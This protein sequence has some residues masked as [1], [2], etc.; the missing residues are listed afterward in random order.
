MVLPLSL[1]RK[2]RWLS[3]I[4]FFFEFDKRD[5]I[6]VYLFQPAIVATGGWFDG[7]GYFF[8]TI[9]FGCAGFFQHSEGLCI[10]FFRHFLHS[11]F[12]RDLFPQWADTKNTR[13]T[14][15]FV[16]AAVNGVVIADEIFEVNLQVII[17]VIGSVA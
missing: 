16:N 6:D 11:R 7:K 9:V 5:V 13:G 10:R 17:A 15:K 4:L 3:R 12:V 8:A 2:W 14:D 1:K